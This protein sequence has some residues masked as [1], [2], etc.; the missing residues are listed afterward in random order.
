MRVDP[1]TLT[2]DQRL[3]HLEQLIAEKMVKEFGGSIENA[4]NF[5]DGDSS[6]AIDAAEFRVL[7]RRLD[8]E[9]SDDVIEELMDRY[10]DD[11]NH[12][13]S[14]IEFELRYRFRRTRFVKFL[15]ERQDER[16]LLLS[17]PYTMLFFVV[18][19][20]LLYARDRTPDMYAIGSG[21]GANI[22]DV[23]T[24]TSGV[25]FNDVQGVSDFYEWVS[26]TLLPQTLIQY[27]EFT[28]GIPLVRDEW[29]RVSV[30][31]N[32]LGT[33]LVFDQVRSN[34]V[35]CAT[36]LG[37]V[38]AP[39]CF[40]SGVSTSSFGLPSCSTSPDDPSCFDDTHLDPTA[41][42][43]VNQAFEYNNASE[44]SM[45]KLN[46]SNS[47]EWNMDV[48]DAIR[49]RGW[50]DK[51]TRHVTIRFA[52]FNGEVS[53][54]SYIALEC[55]FV[56]GGYII[57]TTPRVENVRAAVYDEVWLYGLEGVWLFLVILNAITEFREM[58]SA[59]KENHGNCAE[60][61][62]ED[63]WNYVDWLQIM[64]AIASSVFFFT[65]VAQV[66]DLV[67]E[68]SH[69]DVVDSRSPEP[70]LEHVLD[71]IHEMSI[72]RGVA[73]FNMVV[74]LL[75]FFKAFRGQPRLAV[76]TRTF[77]IAGVDVAHF[78][79]IYFCILAAFV[80]AAV[81]LFGQHVFRYHAWA[82]ALGWCFWSLTGEFFWE[83]VHLENPTMAIVWWWSYLLV[84]YLVLTN[85]FI[86]MVLDSF[87]SAN[88]EQAAK[89]SMMN[90][91]C[92][93]M[94]SSLQSTLLG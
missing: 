65:I 57:P 40:T 82:K 28:D 11:D 84:M 59:A 33:G 50:I 74:L 70:M 24:E 20:V 72:Y 37:N 79:L 6:G 15:H 27:N 30:Y 23:A 75:R 76:I 39:R 9:V 29:G 16:E 94:L 88:A 46:V 67:A 19:V 78:L 58:A 8:I 25:T 14:A 41:L 64:L 34:E 73:L 35:E 90:Q 22:F 7:L 81:V 13:I 60:Y 10:D 66:S 26:E 36:A 43:V 5:A 2:G 12:A 61:W 49:Q 77:V 91:V 31:G 4:F 86:A 47:I 52:T 17:T 18:F 92:C 32:I 62:T 93:Q 87:H 55:E 48:F 85:M 80:A 3:D 83:E 71:I 21:F 63:G 44:T 89:T 56:A 53:V 45:F 42:D 69:S 68:Y 1:E 38:T 51:Q 54:F